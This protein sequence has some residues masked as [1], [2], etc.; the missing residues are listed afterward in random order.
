MA[1]FAWD[2]PKTGIRYFGDEAARRMVEHYGFTPPNAKGKTQDLTPVLGPPPPG[3]YDSTLD[4]NSSAANRGYTQTIND[5]DTAYEQGQQDYGLGTKALDLNRGRLDQDYGFQTSEIG[6][7]YGILGRQQAEHAAQQNV[8][9]A[10]LLGKS[11]QIRGANQGR[12]QGQ[13]DLSH[14]RGIEDIG[15]QRTLLDLDNVRKFG[16]YQGN[17]L[18]NPLTGKPEA[19][20]LLTGTQRA[21]TENDA[22]QQGILGQ[23]V[24]QAQAGGFISPLLQPSTLDPEDYKKKAAALRKAQ[25][26]V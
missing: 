9:S 10:G 19:G 7:N 26:L 20:S 18:I 6:R 21:F 25:G 12:D 13:L 14:N 24:Q 5:A 17:G 2:D 11:A 8:T 4:Y 3:T 15:N 23:K 22:Y 16:G 1:A